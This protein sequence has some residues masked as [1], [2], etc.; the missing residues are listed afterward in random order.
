MSKPEPK[1]PGFNPARLW[2][3]PLWLLAQC[4]WIRI[5]NAPS[6]LDAIALMTSIE[7]LWY[8]AVVIVVIVLYANNYQVVYGK[9]ETKKRD[10]NG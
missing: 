4:I 8:S 9:P 5:D 10:S 6:W 1:Q 7:H 3:I 2:L